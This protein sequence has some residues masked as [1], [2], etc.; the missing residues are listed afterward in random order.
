MNKARR[1][2]IYNIIEQLNQ[3]LRIF[4]NDKEYD[5]ESIIM[6]IINLIQIVFDEEECVMD[7]IPEN[8]QSGYRYKQSEEACDNLYDAIET[9]EDAL[10]D[11]DV[12]WDSVISDAIYSLNNAT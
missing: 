4:K 9:L 2:E 5:I 8:F 11:E 6:D 3:A 12:N 10:E 1:K 7:N